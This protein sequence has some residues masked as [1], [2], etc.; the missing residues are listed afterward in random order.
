MLLEIMKIKLATRKDAKDVAAIIKRHSQSDYM[1]YA[2][3]NEKY[4]LDKMKKNN[5]FFIAEEKDKTVGCIR[6]SIVDLDLAEIRQIC[7]DEGYREKGVA[8]KLLENAL[9]LL[10]KKKMRKVVARSKSDN[11]VAIAL[12]KKFG[13]EQEGY[14]RE[15]YRKGVDVMQMAKFL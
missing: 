7:V 4:I 8:T 11:A 15:H 3:F 6:A 9:E 2:T 1:G 5:F 12:F 10:K 13:F 14:F